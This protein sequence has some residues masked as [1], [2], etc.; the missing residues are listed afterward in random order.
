VLRILAEPLDPRRVRLIGEIIGNSVG[1]FEAIEKNG[2]APKGAMG[3]IYDSVSDTRGA[4]DDALHAVVK[5]SRRTK[6]PQPY[7]SA[8]AERITREVAKRWIEWIVA[9]RP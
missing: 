3:T 8:D 7:S 1:G 2:W 9:R 6:P 5:P 4:G